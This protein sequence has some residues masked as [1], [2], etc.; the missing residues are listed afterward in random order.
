[1]MFDSQKVNF[2]IKPPWIIASVK[3][4][5]KTAA[6]SREQTP[7]GHDDIVEQGLQM[8]YIAVIGHCCQHVA[9]R[10]DENTEENSWV[11]HPE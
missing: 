3:L 5:E 4:T 7:G 2:N 10:N 8:A 1:M 11:I 6:T 9:L